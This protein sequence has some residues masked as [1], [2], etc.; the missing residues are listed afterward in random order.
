[1]LNLVLASDFL[2]LLSFAALAAMLAFSWRG[3]RVSILL[4][5]ASTVSS[6]WF[7]LQLLHHGGW[8]G[9]HA[10]AMRSM[11][12]LR[13]AAWFACLASI[14]ALASGAFSGRR[15]WLLGAAGLGYLAQL[16]LIASPA[17]AAAVFERLP[18][19]ANPVPVGFVVLAALSLE[20]VG[21]LYLYTRQE[22]R[23]SIRPFCLG[24]G[25]LFVYDIF[26]YSHAILFNRISPEL[27]S[28]RGVVNALCVP[29]I[30]LAAG[31]NPK[32]KA[33]IFVSRQVVFH[34]TG[35]LLVGGY[36][37][38]MAAAGYYI[39]EYGGTWGGSLQVVFF[40]AAVLLLTMLTA[41]SQ[42]RARVKV[43]LAK[44]FY[45]NKYEYREEW[46]RFTRTLAECEGER[47][48][49]EET[50]VRAIAGIMECRWGILWLRHET[51]RFVPAS[52]WQAGALPA[53]AE[54][55]V[56]SPFTSLLES[57]GWILDLDEYAEDPS[58]Y[59]N[60]ELPAWLRAMTNAWLVVPL[61]L[62]ERLNGFIV[63][64]RSL[65]N[66]RV[67]W[68]DRDL[69]KTVAQQTASYLALLDATDSLAQ[70]RQFEAY[71]RVS[72]FV[73]HDLKNLAAQLGLVVRNAE[74]YRQNP[75][76]VDDAFTTVAN[77]VAK[78][79]RM[80]ANLRGGAKAGQGDLRRVEL[81]A[82][83]Q[84]V[85]LDRK[86]QR[87]SPILEPAPA[88]AVVIGDRVRLTTAISHLVQ[89]AQ[90]ATAESGTV[91][92][93]LRCEDGWAIVDVADTGC[94]MESQFIRDHLF[95]PFDSTKGN[96]GMG[97][98]VYETRQIIVAHG[99]ELGVQSS[100]GRGSVFTIRLP[101]AREESLDLPA[102][103]AA[104]GGAQ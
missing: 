96:A 14:L 100:P 94:G 40:S 76:F 79:N 64:A 22:Q 45:K 41:S 38:L 68:E 15:R 95:K 78:M 61:P 99:G 42:V 54:E 27:W 18:L 66:E 70:A 72:A 49:V 84:G 86:L 73:V 69:L 102:R 63:M 93:G 37:L 91:T 85:V 60:I 8:V 56:D 28:V 2:G 31:R 57:R 104:T 101:L 58:V 53:D 21:A 32:W 44:H 39:R 12:V 80:L 67:D 81:G 11:E 1:M 74:R 5:A 17:T 4:V 77:A 20:L 62:R 51:G 71:N 13:D 98:G 47:R 36:L 75:E 89:N 25:G 35:V 88:D 30:A 83:L 26:M 103:V 52:Q 33:S 34:G 97:I 48:E 6:A 92:L 9:S 46:L 24:V 87:P 82:V 10:V 43:F 19:L 7:G 65:A 3:G 59:D 50:I 55:P 23:W 16:V 90:E 29:L